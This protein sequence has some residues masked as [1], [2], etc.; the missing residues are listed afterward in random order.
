M[1]ISK[2]VDVMDKTV[3]HIG[4]MTA[5]LVLGLVLL[6]AFNVLARYLFS[7]GTVAMQ[8]LEW[9]L[10]AATALI[11][12]SYGINRGDEVR[13]DMLYGNYSPR[14]KA[15]VD[16][17]AAILMF[18]VAVYLAKLSLNYVAQSYSFNEGSPDPGG[19]PYRYLLKSLITLGFVLLAVQA[20]VQTAKA[21]RAFASAS[22]P[23]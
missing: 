14:T 18:L 13:V 23:E 21:F 17:L 20:V 2:V 5:W 15:I 16:A 7:A 3:D 1:I 11:G 19:L 10:L 6:V 12:M 8:E 22:R 4:R 9:H